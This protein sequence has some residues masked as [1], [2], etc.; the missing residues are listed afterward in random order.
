[1]HGAF[2]VEQALCVVPQLSGA[3]TLQGIKLKYKQ[4]EYCDVKA[5]GGEEGK[6]R[7]RREEKTLEKKMVGV[8][9]Q[10]REAEEE[11]KENL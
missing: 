4:R 6:K 2:T 5:G 7:R 11:R 8:K 10:E 9:V 3:S 1:M